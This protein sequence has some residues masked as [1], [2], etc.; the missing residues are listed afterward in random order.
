MSLDTARFLASRNYACSNPRDRNGL[1]GGGSS[2]Y[3]DA[4]AM[5]RLAE[6]LQSA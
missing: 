1:E 2:I 3:L 4:H 5:L 6:Q